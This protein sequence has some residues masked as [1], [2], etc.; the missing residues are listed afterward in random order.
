MNRTGAKAKE[1]LALMKFLLSNSV[2]VLRKTINSSY[3]IL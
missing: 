3:N 1:L 2:R